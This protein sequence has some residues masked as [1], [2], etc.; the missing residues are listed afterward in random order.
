MKI[1]KIRPSTCSRAAACILGHE[2]RP[3]GHCVYIYRHTVYELLWNL[4]MHV[5]GP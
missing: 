5:Y 4:Y 1:T 2:S 3:R